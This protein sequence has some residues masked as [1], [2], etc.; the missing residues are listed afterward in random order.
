MATVP[1]ALT[2]PTPMSGSKLGRWNSLPLLQ[3]K[4]KQSRR[5]SK[6]SVKSLTQST[7]KFHPSL[8]HIPI[9]IT[10][11]TKNV[12]KWVNDVITREKNFISSCKTDKTLT[13]HFARK[14]CSY[15]FNNDLDFTWNE[16]DIAVIKGM[17]DLNQTPVNMYLGNKFA[18][19]NMYCRSQ[20]KNKNFAAGIFIESA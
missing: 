5:D 10:K 18:L 12:T 16:N 11:Q 7:T 17:D 9:D 2:V 13:K 6:D 15:T 4:R 1:D 19:F 3:Q 14:P 20:D 8:L